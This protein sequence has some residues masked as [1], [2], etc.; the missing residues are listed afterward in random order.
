M[1][2][3][4][5]SLPQMNEKLLMKEFADMFREQVSE[6]I[7]SVKENADAVMARVHMGTTSDTP[8]TSPVTSRK[9]STISL[10]SLQDVDTRVSQPFVS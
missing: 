9:A 10:Q 1:L 2:N 7:Q 4:K 8:L 6:I 5:T 3:E